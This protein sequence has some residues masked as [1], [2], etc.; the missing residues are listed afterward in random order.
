MFRSSLFLLLLL[1]LSSF[2]QDTTAMRFL[3]FDQTLNRLDTMQEG[4]I[5]SARF[6]FTVCN[7]T[8]VQIH[9]VWPGCGCTVVDYPKDTLKP[10]KSYVIELKYYSEGRPGYFKRTAIV[11]YHGLNPQEASPNAEAQLSISGYVVPRPTTNLQ[12]TGKRQ[13]KKSR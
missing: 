13:R 1:P 3:C 5:S 8:P 10:G 9:Q 7:T 2:G 11:L 4:A 6:R 12:V